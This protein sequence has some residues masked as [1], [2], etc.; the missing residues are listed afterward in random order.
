MEEQIVG[1]PVKIDYKWSG[2]MGMGKSQQKNPIIKEI[3]P[4]LFMAARLG[5][6]GVALSASVAEDLV[7]LM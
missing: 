4:Q 2:I 5:G 1:R 6:M 3:E 7:N